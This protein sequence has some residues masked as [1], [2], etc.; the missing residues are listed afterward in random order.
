MKYLNLYKIKAEANLFIFAKSKS[1]LF[2]SV[3]FRVNPFIYKKTQVPPPKNQM[4]VPLDIWS[5]F[6]IRHLIKDSSMHN[7]HMILDKWLSYLGIGTA[8]GQKLN[9]Q[10]FWEQ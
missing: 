8:A 7:C 9:L 4:V 6:H 10:E 5:T 1:N 3:F 2:I